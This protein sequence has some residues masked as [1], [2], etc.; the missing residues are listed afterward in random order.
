MA[1]PAGTYFPRGAP[2]AARAPPG[3]ARPGAPH[4]LHVTAVAHDVRFSDLP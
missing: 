2:G 4:G 3:R 1:S